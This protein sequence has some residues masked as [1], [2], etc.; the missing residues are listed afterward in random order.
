VLPFGKPWKM[1]VPAPVVYRRF[2]N[3]DIADLLIHLAPPGCFRISFFI[4]K[5]L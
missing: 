2:S 3:A 1:K 5:G 4:E